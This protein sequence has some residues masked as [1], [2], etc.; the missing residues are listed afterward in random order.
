M[1]SIG[2]YEEIQPVEARAVR[3]IRSVFE[4]LGGDGFQLGKPRHRE[5]KANL[6]ALAVP[7]NKVVRTAK[8]GSGTY[9][10]LVKV[11]SS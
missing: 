5:I 3:E 4:C 7:A 9:F 10:N 11:C 1:K 6:E 2:E 8:V